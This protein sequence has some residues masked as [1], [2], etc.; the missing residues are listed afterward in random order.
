M[1]K[2][3]KFQLTALSAAIAS[4]LISSYAIGQNTIREEVI[5][6]A[7]RR[8][9]SIQDI[10]I[11]IT[12]LGSD[13][14][15][16]ER[17]TNL[18][19]IARRVPGLIVV[20][21]GPRS[22][23]I[24]TMR[25]L[26][27]DSVAAQDGTNGGGD[28]VGIYIGEVPLYADLRLNDIDRI[29]V[30]I[31]PQG[32]L[33]GAG[34]LGGAVRYIPNKPQADAMTLELRG[35]VYD[36]AK[37][38]TLG[39]DAGATI[40]IPIIEDTLS[41]RASVDYEDDP[42]FIDYNYLVREAGVSN[43]QPDFT[44]PTEV[45]A[46][47]ARKADANTVETLSGRFALRYSGDKLDG[48]LTY[49]Y[50]DSEIGARQINHREA[51]GTGK[52]ESAHRFV[53]P[54]DRT[55]ELVTLE[56]VADLGFAEL[57]SATGYSEYD[58]T[59]QR[60]QTDL[61]LAFQY[62]YESFPS[63]SAFTRDTLDEETLSQ[64]I[65]LVSTG[66]GPL[67]WIVGGFYREYESDSL[68]LE[69][70]PGFAEFSGG[71]R[72][73][74]LEF[75][76][77]FEEEI[78][79]KAVFGE[80]GYQITDAW[81]V[82]VGAR[83]FTF[84]DEATN[85]LA[86]PLADTVFGGSGPDDINIDFQTNEVDDDDVI[87]KFNTSYHFSDDV[88][89]YVTVSEGFRLGGLNS[90]SPCPEVLTP[91]DQNV[92]AQP[93]EVLIKSDTTINYEIGVHSELGDSVLLNASLFFI[94]WDDVQVAGRTANGG[95]PIT[96]NGGTAESSGLEVSGRY[97][98]T[99]ELSI[100]GSYAYTK[101]E[102]S[103]GVLGLID[104]GYD[105]D[106]NPDL[107]IDPGIQPNVDAEDGDRLPGTPEHTIFLSANYVKSLDDGSQID[108]D[109]SMTA[110]SDVLTKVGERASGEA[111]AGFAL[112]NVSATWFDGNYRVSLY[113]DNVFNTY[114]E[115]GVRA[116]SSFT[117]SGDFDMRRYYHN[118]VRPRQV[119]LRFS[120]NFEG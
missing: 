14:I 118:V 91:G 61:L 25:G 20:D 86:L 99:P 71:S 9:E 18:S 116:D 35:D 40:N 51:F 15:E 81:Q 73:D 83:W 26:N 94:D 88:M 1:Y 23:N 78:T 120:Y 54:K 17:L 52:Y 114:G 5:V 32:T 55:N 77:S 41:I 44:N 56:L 34:T 10:P 48:T 47:L 12:A 76:Q 8:A 38:D 119:G 109:W 90:I 60:D 19:D 85:G 27:V 97:F 87:L 110:Q 62:G 104:G 74:A 39:Y 53:E 75:Y 69:F 93:N 112:H 111:L 13:M 66:D 102:L 29:E 113:A 4:T 59:G 16:R 2:N 101:A 58:E 36:L 43:P 50:Q 72:P 42:G 45:R 30:L 57:T 103:E 80:L 21:Q 37:S 3:P 70:A 92:C 98:I 63:F 105:P 106:G 64:E 107:N 95:L 28:T 24:L 22:G 108:F 11:N 46:N 7:T 67:N 89:G 82:T 115:T 6:T 33:Y 84:D 65:R 31:G 49:Y 117:N 100:A 96:T 68:A 79:E